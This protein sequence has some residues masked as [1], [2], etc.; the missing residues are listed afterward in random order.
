MSS[1]MCWQQQQ[2]GHGEAAGSSR[3]MPV[4]GQ[5][6]QVGGVSGA[7]TG[8]WHLEVCLVTL[9]TPADLQ[10]RAVCHGG[11]AWRVQQLSCTHLGGSGSPGC[12]APW[13]G[14]GQVQQGQQQSGHARCSCKGPSYVPVWCGRVS[15][16]PWP[17]VQTH[18]GTVFHMRGWLPAGWLGQ[19]GCRSRQRNREAG[20]LLL[21]PTVVPL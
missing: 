14:Q 10:A 18:E 11:P 6:G 15:Q 8:L 5:V 2:Q 13:H 16:S 1:S 12:E 20:W 19:P 21:A 4:V 9:V 7:T 3:Y 17:G